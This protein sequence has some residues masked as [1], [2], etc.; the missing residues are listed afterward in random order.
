MQ[1]KIYIDIKRSMYII[2][3]KKLENICKRA[4]FHCIS[5]MGFGNYSKP[6][7]YDKNEAPGLHNWVHH[8][9]PVYTR[10]SSSS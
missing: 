4:E 2:L 6:K 9:S 1:N 7:V 10:R 8:R 3:D 5:Q